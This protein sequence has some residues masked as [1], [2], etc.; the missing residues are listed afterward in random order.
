[1][2]HKFVDDTTMTETLNRSD[3]SRM[4]SFIDELIQLATETGMLVNSRKTKE[5]FI[6]S[7]SKVSTP[8]VTFSGAAI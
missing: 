3:V 5:M 8:S 7:T 4:Q 1:M 6:R 2:T